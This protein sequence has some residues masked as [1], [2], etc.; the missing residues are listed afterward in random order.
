MLASADWLGRDE[1]GNEQLQLGAWSLADVSDATAWPAAFRLASVPYDEITTEL[2]RQRLS[3]RPD[4]L[5]LLD[6]RPLETSEADAIEGAVRIPW[7]TIESGAALEQVRSLAAGKDVHVICQSGDWSA[8]SSQFLE[9]Q[10][11]EVTNVSGGMNAWVSQ[12]TE[13]S[14]QQA[15]ATSLETNTVDGDD[16][17][18]VV[19]EPDGSGIFCS[20]DGSK[21]LVYK[22]TG[23][24]EDGESGKSGWVNLEA[25]ASEDGDS[26][27]N[28]EIRTT[29][30]GTWNQYDGKWTQLS[31]AG[32][33]YVRMAADKLG[34][35]TSLTLKAT[36]H[37]PLDLQNPVLDLG[38]SDMVLKNAVKVEADGTPVDDVEGKRVVNGRDENET[39]T[40]EDWNDVWEVA[41]GWPLDNQMGNDGKDIPTLFYKNGSDYS[42]E[43]YYQYTNIVPALEGVGYRLNAL[44][45]YNFEGLRRFKFD[46]DIKGS[47]GNKKG[48]ADIDKFQPSLQEYLA[49]GSV[50]ENGATIDDIAASDDKYAVGNPSLEGRKGQ[51]G[52]WVDFDWTFTL[53]KDG[54]GPIE[55]EILNFVMQP[56]DVDGNPNKNTEGS[57]LLPGAEYVELPSSLYGGEWNPLESLQEE[58]KL[59]YDIL[60]DN[61]P[62]TEYKPQQ[63]LNTIS[64]F[65]GREENYNQ[66]GFWVDNSNAGPWQQM[67]GYTEDYP[68]IKNGGD[69]DNSYIRW[70]GRPH[71]KHG[72]SNSTS[73]LTD[74]ASGAATFYYPDE[75]KNLQFRYG[76]SDQA[77]YADLNGLKYNTSR[78]FQVQ[79]GNSTLTGNVLPDLD[80]D[81]DEATI[82][83]VEC[84]A[85]NFDVVG[86]GFCAK[87]LGD[88]LATAGFTITFGS[89][90]QPGLTSEERLRYVLTGDGDGG[91]FDVVEKGLVAYDAT[92]EVVK[93]GVTEIVG[94]RYDEASNTYQ[95][96]IVVAEGVKRIELGASWKKSNGELTG[97]ESVSLT[98]IQD[99]GLSTVSKTGV[100][101]LD[102]D[103]DGKFIKENCPPDEALP[104]LNFDVVGSGFCAK[105]LGDQLATAGFTITFGSDRQ[106]GLTSEER[107]R[108]VLTGDGDGGDFD[109]VEKGLVAYDATGEVVKRGVTEIV[110]ARYDEAS[111][112]YQGGIVVAEGVKRIELGASWKKSN[113]ELTGDESVSLTVI[114]DNGLSTVSE[115]GVATL[116]HDGDG[117]FIKE[118]CP[119][120]EALPELNFDVVGSG[121]CAK[122]LGD[123]LATAGFTITFGSDRQ[124][125]L[126]S[127]E[128]L[129]YVLTG[130]GDGGDFDVVEKGLVAYDATGE[131]VKRGVTEIVGA[132]YDEASNTYQGGIVVAEGVKRIELGASWKKANGDLTGDE[133][134]S[135][136]VIQDNGLSTV[137]KTGVATL[138]HDGDGKFIK[139][140]CPPD[141]AL[142]ELNFD[143][144][145]SGFCAKDLGDQLATAGFTIT[146][147]SDRQP[148]LTSEERLRYVLTGDGD[149][150]DFDVVE[151]GLVAYDATGEVVKRG[152]TEIVGARYD[153]ASNT[154]QG[155]IVVAEGVKRIELGASWKKSNGELTGDE[156]VSLTVIQDNGLSTVSKTGVATLDHD[157]D[158]KFIKEN[159]PPDEALPELNFDVVGSGFCAK[160][161][162]DQLATAGFTITFGSDRQP[163]LTS[164]ERLRYV[165]TGDGDGGDFDVVEKGLVAYDAT[166]EV[167]KRGVTEIV[168]ARY[169]EASNTYQGGIVV[170][171]GVKRIELGASWKKANGDLT[172]DESVSLTVIQDNGLSTVSKTGVA[173]LDHDGD[174]KFIKENCPPDEALPELNF[175]VVGSGFCAK[176]LGDQLATAGFT[177]TFG[178]DRQPGL[179]SEEGLRYVLTGDGDGGDFDVVEKGLVAYDATGEVVEGGVTEI[180]GARYDEA[181]NT[182]QGAIV[183]AEGVKRIELGASWKK[184]NGDLT[185]EESVSLTVIQDNGLSTVSKTG[186][187]TLDHDGDGNIA[188]NCSPDVPPLENEFE[189]DATAAC[190]NADATQA[191]VEFTVTGKPENLS[192]Y[193]DYAFSY[194]G[195]GSADD[196]ISAP[197][198]TTLD[199]QLLV[200]DRDYWLVPDSDTPGSGTIQILNPALA[201]LTIRFEIVSETPFLGSEQFS[202][203]FGDATTVRRVVAGLD[204]P[205]LNCPEPPESPEEV[206]PMAGTVYL[207]MDNSTSMKG[208]DPS[209]NNA[210]APDRLEAQNRLAFYS[211]QQAASRAGYGFRKIG[212][213]EVQSFG[214]A[215]TNNIINSGSQSLADA[216]SGYELV[217]LPDDG[218]EAQDLTVNLITFGYVVEHQSVTFSADDPIAGVDIAQSIL[219]TTTPDQVYGNSIDGNPVWSERGLP[220]PEARD[221]FRGDGR[222]ASNLYAGT[223]MYGA[224]KGL[225]HLL[226]EQASTDPLT[227]EEFV[228]VALTTDG[229]PERRAWWGNRGGDGTG[230]N[231]ALP[232]VLGGDAVTSAGLLYDNAG[233]PVFVADNSGTQQWT[234]MQAD[235]NRVLDQLASGAAS[236]LTQV[237][238]RAVGM[239]DGSESNFLA[240]YNDLL[241]RQ[242]FNGDAAWSYNYASSYSLPEFFG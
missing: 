12:T 78:F 129:R 172:G 10:G 49:K 160:D 20:T 53:E 167:V 128:R 45:E 73:G 177:I 18:A 162:G 137:S 222:L 27:E 99:N 26:T 204:D 213:Q 80:T 215:N 209:T 208:S 148:G 216:L 226:S 71:D 207:L 123:Q 34:E 212:E 35:A 114:Q 126:T 210:D 184:A 205:E 60:Q 58:S 69:S 61:D 200:A 135:L 118:N 72:G 173:T 25:T 117:K 116:D 84:P 196:T 32:T 225:E 6:V 74:E 19:V 203:S 16:H 46:D 165:L 181:S 229:R 37:A 159:C 48:G 110:G 227:G 41:G 29:E 96:G 232:G 65:D 83:I 219:L 183:V 95:G 44:V 142:P 194:G 231:V 119:P 15:G 179:T 55:V 188:E 171:E 168:G 161:L 180:V 40:A 51:S 120:D 127:E 130:D 109:V 36:Q 91:D 152:V 2:L 50:K 108:Y 103:G 3:S 158:G 131:V 14:V 106:P 82:E 178:S 147:G 164:E 39:I 101:T 92:G 90:R 191:E 107:L 198:I 199:G 182:Y 5:L 195:D 31:D 211:F 175:D 4:D 149:G 23:I 143:V 42:G 89:D 192:G 169:D 62:S 85:I 115:T 133:S 70:M 138:D 176:D 240:I 221:L 146:F 75:V 193:Y 150:G 121:F 185:G 140:N 239:G 47:P 112:T 134:V 56:N 242:T 67:D 154:Y 59:Y 102:H 9:D 66:E 241:G 228:F 235:L 233:N 197:V 104:E 8:A 157:G 68:G 223:E 145:G 93:R 206:P 64:R 17:P 113:G 139:E 87:D 141:E 77:N 224:L 122:D 155:G 88:Q 236:P 166:G 97:D 79:F 163:G 170:A 230:V 24:P 220:Q 136:T 98:V 190:L 201:G 151:K 1:G 86:S 22:V 111:N 156:S 7:P 187:A 217:D 21:Y 238:V 189:L 94:A 30:D 124:P 54:S 105:D 43:G 57:Y 202:F 28:L 52:G 186:V 144:V 237:Q 38:L 125:G 13:A 100:A 214:S 234:P 33:L 174:G 218:F 153:E 63:D 81:T 76:I 11:I 132:R